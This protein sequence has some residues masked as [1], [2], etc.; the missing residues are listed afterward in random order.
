VLSTALARERRSVPFE[1]EIKMLCLRPPDKSYRGELPFP[2]VGKHW[3]TLQHHSL[4]D[5]EVTE[6]VES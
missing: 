5:V 4:T 2:A 6:G 1:L 3:K